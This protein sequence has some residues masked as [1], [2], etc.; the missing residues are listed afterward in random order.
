MAIVFGGLLNLVALDRGGSTFARAIA[1]IVNAL[2]CIMFCF[3]L[4]ILNEPQVYAGII[5]FLITTS[6]FIIDFTRRQNEGI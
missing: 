5:I 6:A 4:A 2:N 1:I 3:A